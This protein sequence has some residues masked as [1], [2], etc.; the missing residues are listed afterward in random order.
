MDR[1]VI[2]AR[3]YTKAAN[4]LRPYR[5]QI[6]EKLHLFSQNPHHSSLKLHQL[7]RV[8]SGEWWS[9]YVNMDV[10]TILSDQKDCW[11][12]CYVGHHDEAYQWARRKRFS[13]DLL[14]GSYSLAPPASE[15]VLEKPIAEAS[16]E[17]APRRPL[18]GYTVKDLIRLGIPHQNEDWAQ[19]FINATE[20]ELQYLLSRALD[21]DWFSQ[22][23]TERLWNLAFGGARYQELLPP[24]VSL[25]MTS[26]LL[27]RY[28]RNFWAPESEAEIERAIRSNWQ[29]WIIF[30]HPAQKAAVERDMQGAI[31]IRGGAG[32]GKTVVAAH[33]TAWLATR[34][35][36]EQVLLTTFTRVLAENLRRRVE[37]I[38]GSLE[39][40]MIKVATLHSVAYSMFKR[41]LQRNE[42]VVDDFNPLLR[43]AIQRVGSEYDLAFVRAEWET[44]I[45]PWNVRTLEKYRTIERI[46]R[47]TQLQIAQREKLWP[48]F[49]QMW[50]LLAERGQITYGGICYAVAEYLQNHPE[51]RYRCVVVDEA[52]DFGPA[53]LTLIRALAPPDEENSLFLCADFRQRIYRPA[54][55]WIRFGI[56]TRGRSYTLRVNYRT[57]AQIQHFAESMLPSQIEDGEENKAVAPTDR[58]FALLHGIEPEIKAYE[59]IRAE[60]SGLKQWI[61]HCLNENIQ[62]GE[63]AIFARTKQVRDEV[64]KL[65]QEVER[66]RGIYALELSRDMQPIADKLNYGTAHNAKGLEFRAVAVVGVSSSNFPCYAVV[67]DV[68]DPAERLLK[69]AEERQLLYTVCTRARER[70]YISYAPA[71]S[72]SPF[73]K[74]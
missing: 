38:I 19:R 36:D 21:E 6:D 58:P 12:V 56:D 29:E 49:E 73:L 11:V 63:I 35:P 43:E 10:R 26:E 13:V 61:Y 57:T 50:Q 25:L 14:Q 28:P 24:Q 44:I 4:R 22:D 55:P 16:T 74:R 40:T 59:N 7:D 46:G 20:D 52:Q 62:P 2:V 48:V 37:Q 33:R 9:Y 68:A 30:L 70:L 54:V 18:S 64:G 60:M 23:V 47:R 41:H 27:R 8:V 69:E 39:G 53:E 32:T 34:Y 71:A 17:N 42:A 15:V 5:K 51:A 66:E 31:R 1:Q 45:E 3:T 65:L 72:P 67:K